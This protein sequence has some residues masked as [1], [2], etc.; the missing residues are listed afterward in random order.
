[1]SNAPGRMFYTSDAEY[2]EASKSFA[3]AQVNL[4][5]GPRML[6]TTPV[7]AAVAPSEAPAPD[8]FS[9]SEAKALLD[10]NPM[11]ARA[12]LDRELQREA[13][14]RRRVLQFARA[15]ALR[16]EPFDDALIAEIDA[17]LA[18]KEE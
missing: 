10:E 18:A 2:E 8:V 12:V 13:G 9:I 11:A 4:A 14:V 15:A 6:G 1:M 7:E 3:Q 5:P 16:Q 17:A